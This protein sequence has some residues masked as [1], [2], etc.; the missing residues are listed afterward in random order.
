MRGSPT[1]LHCDLDA[2]FA[3]VEQRDKPS[4]RGRPVIV[5]GL[6]DRGVVATASYE[7]RRFGVH[8]AMPTAQARRRCPAAAVLGGRFSVYRAVS[9][10]V[11]DLLRTHAPV[12]EATS[13]DEA[14][15]DLAPTAP[16]LDVAGAEAWAQRVRT[17]VRE[18]TGLT[19][20]VGAGTSKLVAKVASDRAKPD[21][22]QV[23]PPGAEQALLDP[24]PVRALPGVGEVTAARLAGVGLLTVA[25]L[26]RT[27]AGELTAILGRAHGQALWDLAHAR[28]DRPV[29]PV[30]EAKSVSVEETFAVD[31]HDAPLLHATL[32]RL[33][34]SLAQRLL[35]AGLSGRTVTLKVRTADFAT[36]ARATTLPAALD[37][38]RTLRS[39]A[40]GL[41]EDLL[42]GTGA[43]SLGVRLLGV[44]VSGLSPWVQGS[45]FDVDDATGT[46]APS[47]DDGDATVPGMDGRAAPRWVPGADVVHPEHGQGWVWGCGRGL[48]TVRFET[49][50]TPPGPIRTFAAD[51]PSLHATA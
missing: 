31:V 3:A 22:I 9:T 10:Q 29:E 6:G 47:H 4:L 14:Y 2:F 23:I 36:H 18:A 43:A 44:G 11:L 45:L 12:V 50:H 40:I 16:A 46:P 5:G 34:A 25:H 41:L 19:L 15:C 17:A 27:S 35:A 13:L 28:D 21:G 8:S 1:L 32:R 39:V 20:S 26:R 51:D 38:E 48:V 42:A 33:A 30:R 49:R 24:L 37:S 7:A